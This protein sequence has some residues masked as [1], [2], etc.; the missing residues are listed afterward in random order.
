MDRVAVSEARTDVRDMIWAWWLYEP[1][2]DLLCLYNPKCH[3][4]FVES[5]G[6][7]A[8]H[9]VFD[10]NV[11]PWYHYTRWQI[12]SNKSISTNIDACRISVLL[13]WHESS[14]HFWCKT[15]PPKD[16]NK[17][18]KK[19]TERVKHQVCNISLDI[20]V[21]YVKFHKISVS[22]MW[23]ECP[24]SLPNLDSLKGA[25][26]FRIQWGWEQLGLGKLRG[27]VLADL[28]SN[29]HSQKRCSSFLDL[30]VCLL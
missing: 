27:L 2:N 11:C 18:A 28:E 10:L 6:M 26:A 8:R 7:F 19:T 3:D 15:T 5:F 17:H 16:S 22:H 24:T 25:T 23:L 30:Q 20:Y 21:Y 1:W 12:D 29:R 13:M 9:Q 14:L 4:L